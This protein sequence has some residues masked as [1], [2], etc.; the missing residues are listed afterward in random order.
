MNKYLHLV[1]DPYYQDIPTWY[2]LV[3]L[4]DVKKIDFNEYSLKKCISSKNT[5]HSLSGSFTYADRSRLGCADKTF[6]LSSIFL[7]TENS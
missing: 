5:V 4:S 7:Y 3:N 6:V 1:F 2:I